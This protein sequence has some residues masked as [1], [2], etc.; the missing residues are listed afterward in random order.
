MRRMERRR[1]KTGGSRRM[2]DRGGR[3]K[4]RMDEDEG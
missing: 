3:R 1:D 2:D 4:S